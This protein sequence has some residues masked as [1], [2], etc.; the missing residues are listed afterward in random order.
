MDEEQ[1]LISTTELSDMDSTSSEPFTTTALRRNTIHIL[2][3]SLSHTTKRILIFLLPTFLQP[4]SDP[5]TPSKRPHPTAW[6]D[7]MRGLAALMV[8]LYHLSYSTHDVYTAY[9]P[10]HK[11]FLRLPLIRSFYNGNFMVSIF[12]VISGFALSWKPVMQMRKA[13]IGELGR[14][15]GRSLVR[16]GVRLYM[17]CFAS[18]FVILV[19]VRLGG[20]EWTRGL[21]GDGE[22]LVGHREYHPQRC[23]GLREQVWVWCK[24]MAGFVNPFSAEGMEMDGHLWT[25]KVEYVSCIECLLGLIADLGLQRASII[26]Y[27]TQLGL[28]QLRTRYRM[29]GLICL[30]A[31]AHQVDRWEMVLF[32]G[33]FILAELAVRRNTLAASHTFDHSHPKSGLLWSTIY[34]LAFIC[35]LYLG[36][37]P[38]RQFEHAPGWSLL[39]SLIPKYIKDWHRYWTGWGALLLVWSTSNHR[40]L[41]RVFTNSVSQYLGKIS[42]SLYLVHG[43]V[44][45]TLG[46]GLLEVL[47][48][49]IGM[50]TRMRKEGCFVLMASCVL[51]VTIWLADIFTRVVDVPSVQFAKWLEERCV[52]KKQ[53]KV[54]PA[55]RESAIV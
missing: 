48:R 17:P 21:A 44:I 46:Y 51:V 13:E 30:I 33:G 35:G 55:W 28:C 19:L 25:I 2:E 41:Q 38:E 1:S 32:Y 15:L 8:F 6:L 23:E 39:H 16:R 18:T 49:L 45:H 31:W 34:I 22:R 40:S 5:R 10:S 3:P 47:W 36:G 53:I 37:Q 54:E 29:L 4:S 52:A 14:G 43:A 9:I 11:E 7:G 50:N 26:L 20:Y 12:F 24:D 27:V 42:F